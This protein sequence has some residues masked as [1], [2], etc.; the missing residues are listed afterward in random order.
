MS[1]LMLLAAFLSLYAATG[2]CNDLN[3]TLNLIIT[4]AIDTKFCL[5]N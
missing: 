5:P 2:F 3:V 1:V 4:A